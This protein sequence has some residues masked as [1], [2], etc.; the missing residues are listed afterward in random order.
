MIKE[1]D[2]NDADYQAWLIANP[3]GFVINT[4]RQEGESL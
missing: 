2:G 1:F 3:H 4:S